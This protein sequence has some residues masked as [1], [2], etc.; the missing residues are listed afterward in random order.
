MSSMQRG[1]QLLVLQLLLVGL[2]FGRL[3]YDRVTLPRVWARTVPVDPNDP[4]RGRYVRLWLEAADARGADSLA[5]VRF[6]V[7]GD[8]LVAMA[9]PDP[10]GVA[11]RSTEPG[12]VVTIAP[13]AFFIPEN[14]ADPSVRPSG[15]DLWAEV[16]ILPRGLPRPLRVELRPAEDSTTR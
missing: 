6:E 13:V 4:F 9:S 10:R 7:D 2:L 5:L 14:I 12:R 1:I 3:A 16:T 11:V 8:R 15:K